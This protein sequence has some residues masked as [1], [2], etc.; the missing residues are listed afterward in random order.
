MYR[1]FLL[2]LF[3]GHFSFCFISHLN[4]KFLSTVNKLS[5]EDRTKRIGS[6]LSDY[7]PE[8]VKIDLFKRIDEGTE[9]LLQNVIAFPS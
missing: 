1:F 2:L 9:P 8:N 5:K 6:L 3:F 7:L 4:R